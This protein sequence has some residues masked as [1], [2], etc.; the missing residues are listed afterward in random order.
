MSKEDCINEIV[1]FVKNSSDS[2]NL[3][4]ATFIAGMKANKTIGVSPSV[5]N[6]KETMKIEKQNG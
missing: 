5:T 3:I 4:I 2:D 6:E 1:S